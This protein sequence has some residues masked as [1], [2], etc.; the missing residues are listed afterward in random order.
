[1]KND[2]ISVIVPIY[3]VEKYLD[4]CINSITNQTY[5]NLEIILVDDGSPDKCPKMCD[6]WAKKD[7][8]IKVIHKENGGLS[9]ARN[10][11]IDVAKGK[12]LYFVDSD[13]F[14]PNYSIEVLYESIIKTKKDIS[15]GQIKRITDCNYNFDNSF[16]ENYI[17]NLTIL[18]N[19]SSMEQLLYNTLYS[20]STAGK[21]FNKKVLKD[22]RFPYKKKYEDLG[23]TYKIIAKSNG[24]AVT[25]LVVYY[26]FVA[27]NESIMNEKFSI[28]RLTALDFTLDIYDFVSKK[29]KNIIKSAETRILIES[30]DIYLNIPNNKDYKEIK[31]NV[32]GYIKKYRKNIFI[33]K[34][35]PFKKKLTLLPLVF[36]KLGLWCY[37]KIKKLSVCR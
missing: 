34:K 28:D 27:R 17:N 18:N 22:I 19:N 16:D 12:Y 30:R 8:R 2:L 9:D 6:N 15:I 14:V 5:S 10:A 23:T 24:V 35:I 11:G 1:M 25:N 20:S 29:Y 32:Y 7:N 26:Y 13:D 31:N 4:K 33:D 21:L 37:S 3:N 36:G